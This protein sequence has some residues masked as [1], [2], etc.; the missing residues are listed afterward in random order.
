MYYVNA[1]PC[2][3]VQTTTNH[4]LWPVRIPRRHRGGSAVMSGRCVI[5]IEGSNLRFKLQTRRFF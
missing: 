3:V 4:R 1:F 5:W 2:D